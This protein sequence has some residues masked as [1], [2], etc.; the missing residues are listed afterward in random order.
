MIARVLSVKKI[1]IVEDQ[2]DVLKLLE[3]VLRAEVRKI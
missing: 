1:L 3:I 2:V